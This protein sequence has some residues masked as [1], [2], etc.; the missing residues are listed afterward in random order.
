MVSGLADA[1]VRAHNGPR[2][3]REGEGLLEHGSSLRL[4]R[5]ARGLTLADAERA[6]R[7]RAR[8]LRALEEGQLDLLPGGAYPRV[9]LRDYAAY[10][11]LDPSLLLERLPEPEPEISPQPVGSPIRPLPW[12]GAAV[13]ALVLG[14][15]AAAS[16]W[17]LTSRGDH[18]TPTA[19]ATPPV[20]APTVAHKAAAPPA[21]PA[22]A[23][24]R[25]VRG[26]S[27]VQVSRAGRV[28]WTGILR[29]GRTLRLGVAKPLVVRLG[30][31][32]NVDARV[33]GRQLPRFPQHPVNV[34]LHA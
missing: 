23:T 17:A 10:L 25:A 4:T 31:P 32:W 14:C 16:L 7:V 18:A 34:S 26:E 22:V 29:Q 5:E 2:D 12:R 1:P 9:F 6:T 28:L 19:H 15:V 33:A 8:Y 21:P 27:W 20:A 24:L 13:T 3:A 11:G 30:A